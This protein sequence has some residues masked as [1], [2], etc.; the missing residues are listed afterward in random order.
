MREFEGL[1]AV[2]TGASS[3]IGF[4]T[5]TKLTQGG[6]I[7]FGLDLSPG[8]VF[9]NYPWIECDIGDTASVSNAF[10]LIASEVSVVD[11]LVNNAGIG[12]VGTIES[13]EDAVWQRVLNINV[14]GTAR[15]SREALPFLRLSKSTSIVNVC[16]IAATAGIQARALYSASKGAILS[17]T[18]AMAADHLQDGIRVNCVNPGTADTPW[19]QRLLAAA[20]D[21][22]LALAA[23]KARQPMGRLVTADEV[24][25][26]ICFLASPMSSSTT[27]TSV[28]V[29]GGM[30]GLR[31]K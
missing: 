14:V 16:S 8:V 27:G 11:I 21:T 10:K 1:A 28:A 25:H 19:V 9:D 13:T 22:D 20:A 29:D 17:L 12:A 15:V 23:L 5:A 3:G 26:A 31:V 2:V 6:A 24:A 4:A 18:L 7:V 30:Q